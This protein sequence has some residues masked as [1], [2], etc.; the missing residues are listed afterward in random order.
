MYESSINVSVN[1]VIIDPVRRQT[2]H[3]RQLGAQGTEEI[4][5]RF[6]LPINEYETVAS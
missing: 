3:L 2:L 1:R 6:Q 4:E 5:I